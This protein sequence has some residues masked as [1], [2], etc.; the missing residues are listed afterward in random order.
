MRSPHS[1][2]FIPAIG[3]VALFAFVLQPSSIRAASIE[4]QFIDGPGEGFFDPTPF[5]PVGGNPAT[6][7]GEARRI[8]VKYAALI[9]GSCLRSDVK[10]TLEAEMDPLYCSL[11]SGFA[12]GQGFGIGPEK[13]FPNAPL[14][15][16]W[17]PQALANSLAGVDLNPLAPELG[18]ELNS[19]LDVN[20]NCSNSWYYGLDAIVPPGKVDLVTASVHEILHGLGMQTI[21]RQSDGTKLLGLDGTYMLNLEHHGF[22]PPDFPSMTDAERNSCDDGPN[23]HWVGPSTV[24]AALSIPLTAGLPNGHVHMHGGSVGHFNT[25]LFPNELMEPYPNGANHS[26]GLALYVLEDIGWNILPKNGTDIVFIMDITGS[27][28]ALMASWLA[29]IPAIS[30]LWLTFDPNARFAVVSHVDYPFEPHSEP[31]T[32]A[33]RVESTLSPSLSALQNGL[34]NITNLGL[35]GGDTAESQYEAI[36]QVLTGAGRDLSGAVDYSGTGEFPPQPLG[37]QN[38]M[39]IYHFTWPEQFHDQNLEPNYPFPGSKPVATES[40][41][42]LEMAA[43]SSQS[44]FFGLTTVTAKRK[45]SQGQE[46][47]LDKSITDGPLARIAALSGGAVYDVGV[48]LEGLQDAIAASIGHWAASAQGS[49]DPDVDGIAPGADNCN[50][51]YNPSQGDSDG[52]QVGDLCDNCPD[53]ANAD[54]L[55]CNLDGRGDRCDA[56]PCLRVNTAA[57]ISRTLALYAPA[58]NPTNAFAR[59]EFDLPTAGTVSLEIFDLRGRRV[60]SLTPRVFPAGRSTLIWDGRDDAHHVVAA[61][62]Y[63]ARLNANGQTVSKPVTVLK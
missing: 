62:V 16:V 45:T 38:P 39:V 8:V 60:R 36:Y 55:D 17:Y 35:I 48:D 46:G 56:S 4:V 51:I 49:G 32:W 26:P 19:D 50:Y 29:Q 12:L 30:A 53:D 28:G 9:A 58:P 22:I 5:T 23:V 3:L 41:V 27:T 21:Y 42:V 59:F 37:Q 34:S 44:M 15:N 6:T 33:Y 57:P 24:N 63:W 61:G 25:A 7:L 18:L 43:A 20:P 40:D 2:F 54:Q 14:P 47:G 10:I 1:S 11:L 31:A 13:T 52:D